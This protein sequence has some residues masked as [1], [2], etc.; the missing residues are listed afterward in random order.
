MKTTKLIITAILVFMLVFAL[1]GCGDN[2]PATEGAR[3][4]APAETQ[5]AATEAPATEEPA[6]EAPDYTGT[7]TSFAYS[8]DELGLGDNLIS[9]EDVMG[10]MAFTL[11]DDGTGTA[12][13]DGDDAEITWQTDG[14]MLTMT[15]KDGNGLS[16]TVNDGVMDVFMESDGIN[17][18]VYLAKPDADTSTYKVLSLEEAMAIAI[19]EMATES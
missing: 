2:T 1:C 15:T 18:H 11:N 6:T 19:K 16:A 17:G 14:E 4:D 8:A 3:D 10:T 5:A 13:L 7:Y 12:T 9:T